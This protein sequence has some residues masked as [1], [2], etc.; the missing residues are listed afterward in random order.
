MTP[1]REETLEILSKGV[2]GPEKAQQIVDLLYDDSTDRMVR[3][4]LL[5]GAIG[6]PP[7]DA[8]ALARELDDTAIRRQVATEVNALANRVAEAEQRAVNA[9]AIGASTEL[10]TPL[11]DSVRE[12]HEAEA[13]LIKLT[14]GATHSGKP[15][16][17]DTAR[18]EWATIGKA[19]QSL[20]K[21][22]IKWLGA[23]SPGATKRT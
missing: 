10:V 20:H 5:A 7:K 23:G 2:F 16:T 11:L 15:P 19:R 21:H 8:A 14:I 3:F 22:I 18:K 4:A 17:K 13:E 12:V 6:M 1:T 9:A